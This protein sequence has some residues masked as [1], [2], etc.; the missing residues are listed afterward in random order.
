MWLPGSGI[1]YKL[2][3]NQQIEGEWK[4]YGTRTGA[5]LLTI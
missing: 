2:N 1:N 5:E 3:F 4:N